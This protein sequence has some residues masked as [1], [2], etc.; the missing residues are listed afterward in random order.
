MIKPGSN[1][2]R[3][4]VIMNDKPLLLWV[5]QGTKFTDCTAF[6]DRTASISCKV[7]YNVNCTF[8]N[9]SWIKNGTLPKWHWNIFIIIGLDPSYRAVHAITIFSQKSKWSSVIFMISRQLMVWQLLISVAPILLL[10]LHQVIKL[11]PAG[12]VYKLNYCCTFIM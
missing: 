5:T 3:Q 12:T 1:S 2:R 7:M 11:Y 6:T 9:I 10:H 4:Y 8:S